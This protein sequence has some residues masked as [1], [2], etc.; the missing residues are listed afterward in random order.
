I[1]L[2][3]D[4]SGLVPLIAN[5]TVSATL[6]FVI[7]GVLAVWT[8]RRGARVAGVVLPG[9][10]AVA[11]DVGG[12]GLLTGGW[13]AGLRFAIVCG[14]IDAVANALLLWGLRIGDLSVM[15]VL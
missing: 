3:P 11:T 9:G 6:M 5:R 7:I 8:A 1:D 2:T 13:R 14:V 15:A 4:D 10:Q 12:V